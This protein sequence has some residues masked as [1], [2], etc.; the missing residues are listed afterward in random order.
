MGPDEGQDFGS[1]LF[2]GLVG[3]LYDGPS[4][5]AAKDVLGIFH[6]AAHGLWVGIVARGSA[7]VLFSHLAQFRQPDGVYCEAAHLPWSQIEQ[8]RW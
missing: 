6:F 2:D 4:A 8:T 5:L 1:D 7:Q 3:Y